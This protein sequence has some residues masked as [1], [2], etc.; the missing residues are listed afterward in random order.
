MCCTASRSRTQRSQ[1]CSGVP[2]PPRF[3]G[4]PWA[5]QPRTDWSCH[6]AR[7]RSPPSRGCAKSSAAARGCGR[8]A[9]NFS[10]QCRRSA[11]LAA[12]A[13]RTTQARRTCAVSVWPWHLEM[14]QPSPQHCVH[15]EHGSSGVQSGNGDGGSLAVRRCARRVDQREN[16]ELGCGHAPR[17]SA[18]GAHFMQ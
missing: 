15:G 11:R 2:S 5:R 3:A 6:C 7:I 8:R 10:R 4:L 13:A 9:A 14:M 1:L 12:G 18:R 16:G 17:L